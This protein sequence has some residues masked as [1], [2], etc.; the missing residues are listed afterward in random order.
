VTKIVKLPLTYGG[1]VWV[2]PRRIL[3]VEH[4]ASGSSKVRMNIPN[5]DFDVDLPAH[6]VAEL[7]TEAQ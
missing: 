4:V 1:H 5:L 7:L 2:N 3:V 6:E